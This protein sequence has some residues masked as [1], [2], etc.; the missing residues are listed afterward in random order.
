MHRK[1]VRRFVT[2]AGLVAAQSWGPLP[3]QAQG[4]RPGG[5]TE[6]SASRSSAGKED[7]DKP[8]DEVPLNAYETALKFVQKGDCARAREILD[9]IILQGPGSEVALLDIGYCYLQKASRPAGAEEARQIRETGV[10]WVLRAGNAGLRRAEEE[11]VR[12]YLEGDVFLP[13]P[14]E[15]A[16]W[17][18]LWK[19][20]RNSFQITPPE[21]DEKLEQKLQSSLSQAD[22]TVARQRAIAWRPVYQ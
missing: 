15:A 21:F 14:T 22:W 7:K 10:G 4:Y 20:N 11:L 16:K 6:P 17:Y 18:L 12:Q 2:V 19:A 1:W 9:Q 5:E 13:D 8:K 3:A